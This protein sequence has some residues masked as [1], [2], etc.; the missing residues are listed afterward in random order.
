MNILQLR[1]CTHEE[2]RPYRV[3]VK[4]AVQNILSINDSFLMEV[5][6]NEAVNNALCNNHPMNPVSLSMRVSSR[7]RLIIRIKDSGEGFD[8]KNALKDLA[9][10]SELLFERNLTSESGRG[11]GI[12]NIAADKMIYNQ[13][14]NELLLMKYIRT[15]TDL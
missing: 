3:K 1:F 15:E 2:F 12:I 5:A 10:S 13:K 4:A 6:I 8:V 7:K 9:S 11:I 14:G